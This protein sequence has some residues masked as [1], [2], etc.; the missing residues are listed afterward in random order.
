MSHTRRILLVFCM[1]WLPLQSV[2]AALA[3]AH[4]AEDIAEAFLHIEATV[5]PVD[6]DFGVQKREGNQTGSAN[7]HD[8]CHH[9]LTVA[10]VQESQGQLPNSHRVVV[11]PSPAWLT[12]FPDQPD[13]PKWARLAYSGEAT[14]LIL[15]GLH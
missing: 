5:Q 1:L 12:V 3:G 7:T 10:V 13:P 11:K 8:C 4:C 2:A 9:H 15:Q 14:M 6:Q